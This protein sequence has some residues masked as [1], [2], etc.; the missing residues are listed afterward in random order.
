M[1]GPFWIT[2][3]VGLTNLYSSLTTTMFP[4]VCPTNVALL[5]WGELIE[6]ASNSISKSLSWTPAET[7]ALSG[8]LQST[9]AVGV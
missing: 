2:K 7:A 5:S 1:Y 4:E 6:L 8:C 9:V 3:F